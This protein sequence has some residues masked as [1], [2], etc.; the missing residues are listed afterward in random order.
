M[1]S[2]D[3]T[4]NDSKFASV[5]ENMRQALHGGGSLQ[6]TKNRWFDKAIQV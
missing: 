3:N 4:V 1:L 5:D 2:L 6:N